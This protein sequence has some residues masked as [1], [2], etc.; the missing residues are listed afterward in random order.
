MEDCCS[1]EP[2]PTLTELGKGMV[3]QAEAKLL[4]TKDGCEILTK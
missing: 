4:V 1:L 3:S 2:H